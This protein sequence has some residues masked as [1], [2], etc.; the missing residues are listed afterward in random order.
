MGQ[1]QRCI[2]SVHDDRWRI[3]QSTRAQPAAARVHRAIPEWGHPLA[4]YVLSALVLIGP[5]GTWVALHLGGHLVKV[6]VVGYHSGS[7]AW[8]LL[9]LVV[10]AVIWTT[11]SAVT[12]SRESRIVVA[13]V[14]AALTVVTGTSI[15]QYGLFDGGQSPAT[16]T[17]GWGMWLCFISSLLGTAIAIMW[18]R[19]SRPRS[20]L[21]L[22]PSP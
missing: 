18:V 8:T 1:S 20:Q 11:A 13:T 3:C 21:G 12:H 16:F 14:F 19:G 2:R 7:P 9:V 6:A 15:V 4:L 22:E 5:F 17:I 10:A